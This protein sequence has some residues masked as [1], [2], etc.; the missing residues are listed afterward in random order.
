PCQLKGGVVS[1]AREVFIAARQGDDRNNREGGT[2][3]SLLLENCDLSADLSVRAAFEYAFG[4]VLHQESVA[5]EP[6]F[7]ALRHSDAQQDFRRGQTVRISFA[8][9]GNAVPSE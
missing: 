7:D 3:T 5:S 4:A 8:F 2:E 1:R 9:V 6:Q